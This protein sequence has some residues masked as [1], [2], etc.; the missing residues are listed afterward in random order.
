MEKTEFPMSNDIGQACP[1]PHPHTPSEQ[2]VITSLLKAR[3]IAVVGM[4]PDTSR[5]GH[6]VPAFLRSRGKEILPVTPT[7]ATID[8]LKTYP[9]LAQVPQPIDLVL[10]FRRPEYCPQIARE[11]AQ[12]HAAG[13]WLQSGIYSEE[14]KKIAHQANI[15]F[16]QG[17]CMMVELR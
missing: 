14:A 9:T 5:A 2:E 1:M 7:H 6:Y 13:L 8:G 12:A 10:V 15:P 11:A 3:R 17:R 4:T 16:V